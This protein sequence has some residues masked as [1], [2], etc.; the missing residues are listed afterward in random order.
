LRYG[1]GM[2]V[3]QTPRLDLLLQL[4]RMARLYWRLFRDP[5]VSVWPKALLVGALAYVALPID[6]VPDTLPLLG[7]IDDVVIVLAVAR[8][9]IDLCPPEVVWEHTRAI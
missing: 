6:L 7:E 2:R 1:A 3:T 9:F 4:P 5:R 8:W